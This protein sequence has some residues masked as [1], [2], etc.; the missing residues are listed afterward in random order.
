[1]YKVDACY[2]LKIQ[3]MQERLKIT[4]E[5]P[6]CS[7]TTVTSHE[8]V[9]QTSTLQLQYIIILSLKEVQQ[10]GTENFSANLNL[11]NGTEYFSEK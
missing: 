11:E 6:A 3:T 5:C 10:N 7:P 2:P 8:H 4:P 9:Q 1:M